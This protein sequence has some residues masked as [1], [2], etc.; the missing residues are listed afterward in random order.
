MIWIDL[1][2]RFSY[3]LKSKTH[4]PSKDVFRVVC[5]KNIN[6]SYW[7]KSGIYNTFKADLKLKYYH[8]QNRLCAYCRSKLRAKAYWEDLDHIVPQSLK[9]NWIF[10][11]RNLI[12]TCQ[13][14]NRLKND[15]LTITNT[16]QKN[17]PSKGKLFKIF[18]PHFDKW[19]DHF[20]IEKGIFLKPKP[21]TKGPYTYKHC[22]LYR[23]D[24]LLEY[25]DE[26]RIWKRFTMK[27][28]THR[29]KQVKSGSNE[30]KHIQEAIKE[31]IRRNKQ[32]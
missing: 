29:L 31:L 22:H 32:N 24:V 1:N 27:R 8:N 3:T 25:V 11:P 20:V 16:N 19:E 2:R 6:K 4:I 9:E 28:L 18:N 7:S 5:S 21:G 14:C 10:Q 30:E 26:Q 13:P 23:Y 12:V 15:E 17:F